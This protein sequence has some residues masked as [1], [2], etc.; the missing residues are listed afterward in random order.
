MLKLWIE[1]AAKAWGKNKKLLTAIVG[2]LRGNDECH[3]L[4]LKQAKRGRSEKF[5]DS[6]E[7]FFRSLD[8]YDWVAEAELANEK[9]EA[10]IA[11]ICAHEGVSRATVFAALKEAEEY[12]A[13]LK[14]LGLTPRLATRPSK[15]RNC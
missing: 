2:A 8:W 9:T 4:V 11:D 7:S 1:I 15:G 5:D 10:V 13:L 6:N 14:K 12:L 3:S